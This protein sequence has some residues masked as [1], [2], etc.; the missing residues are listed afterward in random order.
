MKIV[1]VKNLSKIYSQKKKD[2]KAVD[3]ISFS[4][5]R[6]EILG[7][8]GPNGAGKTTTIKCIATLIM[9]T[10]GEVFINGFDQKK[11]H[12]KVLNYISAVLEGNRNIYWRLTVKEN[13]NF[14]SGLQGL[15]YKTNKDYIKELIDFFDLREKENIQG[16]YLSRGM[17]QKLAVASAFVKRT[18]VLLLDEPTLGLDVESTHQLKKMIL[19]KALNEGRTIILSSHNMKLIEDICEKVIIIN[20]GKLITSEKVSS[21]KRFFSVNAYKFQIEGIIDNK[22]KC[23]MKDKF[24]SAE[25]SE[26]EKN[27]I[28]TIDFTNLDKIY[29]V[30]D[31]LKG[32]NKKIL[33]MES[34]EPDFEQIYLK[35]IRNEKNVNSI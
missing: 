16:R 21:L 23:K 33:K 19:D 9:P 34:I 6:G 14:F 31:I 15:N 30:F 7:F 18:D 28:M 5:E 27:T 8:L 10:S 20:E 29:D 3:N 4:I 11:E 35:I 1:E 13:L 17:Q 24:L 2:I 25:F 32:N 22:F 26:V 12:S